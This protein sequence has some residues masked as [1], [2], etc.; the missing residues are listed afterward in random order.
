MKIIS[1][2]LFLCSF[3]ISHEIE[4]TQDE[5]SYLEKK[6]VI[7]MCVDPDWEPFEIINDSGQHEGIAT[8]LIRLISSRVYVQIQLVATKTWEES[9]ELSKDKR[10]D[11]LS[12]LNETP[13][14]K[15]WLIFTQPLFSDPNVLIARIESPYIDNIA[16]KNLSIALPR[17]TAMSER[18]AIDFPNLTII[19]TTTESEAFRL[20][21]DKKADL[22]LR[23]LIVTA[24]TIKKDGLFNLKIVNQPKGYENHLRIG[25]R[26]DE[27]IL[28]EILDKGIKTLSKSDRDSII[29][30]HVAIVVEEVTLYSVWL[31]VLA[32]LA[33]LSL[34]II[35][36]N[37]LLRKKVV[38]EVAKNLAKQEQLVQKHKQAEL[39]ILVGNIAHQWRDGLSS[40][41]SKNMFLLAKIDFGIEISQDEIKETTK[42]IEKSIDFMSD[43][44]KSFLQFYKV[45]TEIEI[46]DAYHSIQETM[47]II[48]LKIKHLRINIEF[49][50]IESLQL[51]GIKNEWMNVWLNIFMNFI[52][53][54]KQRKLLSP[55]I[56]IIIE[57][58]RIVFKDNGGG[59]DIQ[60]LENITNNKNTGLGLIISKEIVQKY[61]W[62]LI[63][64]NISYG[65]QFTIAKK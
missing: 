36:W 49:H 21:E 32:V 43:T 15:E 9:I 55:H 50:V 60:H 6:K 28:K 44:M 38:Q 37:Y 41:G 5:R 45:S 63:I 57:N 7:T 16:T 23:S 54:S 51:E 33:I 56:D 62:Y 12:F 8:D 59:F 1:L 42:M 65:A 20:V 35:F 47:T 2:L 39:G 25:V 3:I 61:N 4:L 17:D 11:I 10:C 31:W 26:K 24:Y 14:R 18:F 40:I 52:N 48:D 19:P 46:F 53:I 27:P 64:E 29:N 13:Q 22:T 34:L 30:N 58:E